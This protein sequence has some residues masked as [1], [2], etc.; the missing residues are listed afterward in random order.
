MSSLSSLREDEA[1]LDF[2]VAEGNTNTP[3]S[4]LRSRVLPGDGPGQLDAALVVARD[5]I[6]PVFRSWEVELAA[7]SRAMAALSDPDRHDPQAVYAAPRQC[8]TS[9]HFAM[10]AL[11]D[12]GTALLGPLLDQLRDA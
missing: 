8:T 1:Y 6:A 4:W 3:V 9:R 10:T 12:L 2:L 5:A 11:R 7:W